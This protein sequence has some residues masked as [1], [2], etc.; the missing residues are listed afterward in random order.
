MQDRILV[1][2]LSAMGDVAMTVPVLSALERQHPEVRVILLSRKR[3]KPLFRTLKNVEFVEAQVQQEHKGPLG[4]YRLSRQLKK[5]TPT[6]IAD[7]HDSLRSRVLK[8]LL[9]LPAQTIDKL[10][11]QRKALV[12]G[13][14]SVDN[15]LPSVLSRYA[16]VFYELGYPVVPGPADLLA[17]SPMPDDIDQDPSKRWVGFAPFAAHGGKSYPVD[18]CEQLL[19][20]LSN[21]KVQ[22]LLFGGPDDRTQYELWEQQFEHVTSLA[23]R[24]YMEQELCAISNLDAMISMD[25]G[26]GHLAALHG[27]PTITVWGITHPAM[28]FAP[29]LQPKENQLVADLEKFPKVPTSA[30]GN[31]MPDGYEN[32]IRSVTPARI[33]TRLE[34]ILGSTDTTD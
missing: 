16:N 17:R 12:N 14:R 22:V 2:R 20:Q 18:L 34:Q 7:L 28:G 29:F 11:S 31:K 32:A 13:T 9:D 33:I 15:D 26:N 25:S 30:Y 5:R 27:I 1:I 23:G 19:K 8:T 10:R 4:L 6:A 21:C 3:F 24:F